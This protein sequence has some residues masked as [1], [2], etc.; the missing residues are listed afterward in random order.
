M[1]LLT[2][3]R[4]LVYT[5]LQVRKAANHFTLN[6]TFTLEKTWLPFEQ[7]EDLRDDH[8]NGKLYVV[9]GARS[10]MYIRSRSNMGVREYAVNLGFQRYINTVN[11]IAE[12]DTYDTFLEEVEGVL[13]T[14]VLH[15]LFAFSRVQYLKDSEGVPLSFI[16][17]RKNHV[18]EAYF[19]AFYT[20]VKPAP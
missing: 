10:D 12:I 2:D 7:L 15:D 8:P 20:Y 17:L 1:S 9:C 4:D 19:T 6:N 3:L 14:Y 18:F 5:T 11:D 13:Q 16:H